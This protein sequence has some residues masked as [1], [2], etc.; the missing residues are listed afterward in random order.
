MIRFDP[1]GWFGHIIP[2]ARLY[3]IINV[4]LFTIVIGFLIVR[5]GQYRGFSFKPLWASETLLFAVLAIAF[6][7]R[8]NPVD[9]S[10]G[11]R[12]IIVP[13]IGSV[14]PFGL[15]FT[16][17]SPWI[18]GDTDL[19]RLVF[20][21]MTLS[22]LFTVWGMWTLRNSFSITVEARQLVTRGPYRW[23]RHPVYTGEILS[24]VSVVVW[25]CSWLNVLIL[26][27]FVI[28]Q[29][30]RSYWEEAKLKRIFPDYKN[31]PGRSLWVWS[32]K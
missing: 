32:I 18:A 8:G 22:T 9:R 10:Q 5:I 16:H 29:I 25:R 17:P 12:E 4:C 7:M 21:W 11:I 13:L 23:V 30:S 28:I 26:T 14:L 27:L 19:L 20:I 24:A 3:R 2:P 15:L 31:C 6:I 1:F